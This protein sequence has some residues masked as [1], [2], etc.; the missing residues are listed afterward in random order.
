MLSIE[1]CERILK[2][3]ETNMS[4]EDIIKLRD[5]LY[6]LAKLEEENNNEL[7]EDKEDESNFVL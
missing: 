7:K 2:E 6:F 3:N 1:R 4:R 5:Y